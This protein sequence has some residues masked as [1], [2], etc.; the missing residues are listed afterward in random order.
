M[1]FINKERVLYGVGKAVDVTNATADK[2]TTYVKDNEIDKKAASMADS[3][4]SAM[5]SAGEKIEKTVTNM[6]R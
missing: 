4:G 3:I 1:T 2:V 5:K 6:F